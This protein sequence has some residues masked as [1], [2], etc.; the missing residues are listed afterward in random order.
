MK[1]LPKFVQTYDVRTPV[2]IYI[3]NFSVN[4]ATGNG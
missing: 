3:D 4:A 1:S 2:I